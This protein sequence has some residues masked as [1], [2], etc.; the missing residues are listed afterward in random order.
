M[1]LPGRPSDEIPD[2]LT[3]GN[4]DITTTFVSMS[5]RDPDVTDADYLQWHTLDH[6]P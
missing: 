2:V 6:R 4:G 3:T 5:T 1:L